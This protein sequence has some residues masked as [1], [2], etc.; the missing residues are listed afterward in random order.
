MWWTRQYVLNTDV[1][2][3]IARLI[4]SYLIIMIILDTYKLLTEVSGWSS[5]ISH[6]AP[7]LNLEILKVTDSHKIQTRLWDLYVFYR[8]SF[9]GFGQ[10]FFL[11]YLSWPLG[12]IRHD[13]VFIIHPCSNHQLQHLDV[14]YFFPTSCALF[15][16]VCAKNNQIVET[17]TFIIYIFSFSLIRTRAPCACVLSLH[18]QFY[19]DSSG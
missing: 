4:Y 11:Q 18:T 1:D 3:T 19:F 7:Y 6:I 13:S 16:Q 15:A 5:T 10:I 2:N 14:L 8:G 17:T 9:C 12:K